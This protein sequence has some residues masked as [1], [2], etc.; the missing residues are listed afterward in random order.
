MKKII[1]VLVFSLLMIV[2]CSKNDNVVGI[3]AQS[4]LV[5]LKKIESIGTYSNAVFQTGILTYDGNKLL[6]FNSTGYKEIYTY[7]GN[8]ITKIVAY[9]GNNISQTSEFTYLNGSLSTYISNTERFRYYSKTT[10]TNNP[11]GTI[12]Y[13]EKSIH[14]QNLDEQINKTGSLTFVNGNLIKD[15]YTSSQSSNVIYSADVYEYDNKNSPFKNILGFDKL[16]Q[17]VGGQKNLLTRTFITKYLDSNNVTVTDT[18]INGFYEYLYNSQDYPTQ[19]K[20]TEGGILQ[21]TTNYFY[22]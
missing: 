5:L 16:Y 8:L 3:G 12:S 19:Q 17:E 20:F 6:E 22:D 11:D 4:N 13:I 21:G 9:D 18:N 2:G 14:K 10:Y 1:L 7:S 15:E